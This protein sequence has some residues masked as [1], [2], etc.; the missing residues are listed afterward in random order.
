MQLE[1]FRQIAAIFAM[2]GMLCSDTETKPAGHE[3]VDTI[4]YALEYADRLLLEFER[5]KKKDSK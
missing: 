1:E 5:T 2:H 4:E 3:M